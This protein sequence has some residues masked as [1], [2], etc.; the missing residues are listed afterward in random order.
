MRPC[1][2]LGGLVLLLAACGGESAAPN[3]PAPIYPAVAGNYQILGTFDGISGWLDGTFSLQQPT[4]TEP[5]LAGTAHIIVTI[6]GNAFD[7][8]YPLSGAHV[9]AD[10]SLTFVLRDNA[11]DAWSFS[12][13][14]SGTTVT[15]RHTLISSGFAGTLTGPF[16]ASR[17]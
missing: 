3:P 2:L 13:Q 10:G 14:L 17:H 4:R 5:G 15:G 8:D 1:S 11:T 6:G 7:F 9:T 12:G 16:E